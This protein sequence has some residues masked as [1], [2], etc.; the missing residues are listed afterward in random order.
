MEYILGVFRLRELKEDIIDKKYLSLN[1]KS[2][3]SLYR[4]IEE[5]IDLGIP[6]R[7]FLK[8]E[9]TNKGA[10]EDIPNFMYIL[11]VYITGKSAE[12]EIHISGLD[13]DEAE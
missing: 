9:V 3:R 4:Y 11:L 7:S 1:N 10:Y 12:G 2:V 13:M 6:V 5:A 8:F